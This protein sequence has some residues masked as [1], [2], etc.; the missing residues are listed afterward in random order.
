M[1]GDKDEYVLELQKALKDMGFFN[2]KPTGYFGTETQNAVIAFQKSRQMS[3]DGKAGE[4]TRKLLLG[5]DYKPLP[6][7]RVASESKTDSAKD[8][9]DVWRVGDRG[10]EVAKFQKRLKEL[11]YYTYSKI[12]QY[13]GPITE[14]AVKLFQKNNGLTQDGILGPKTLAKLNSKNAKKYTAAKSTTKASNTST[15]KVDKMISIAKKYIGKPYVLGGN[16]PSKF[17]C[18]GFT[19]FVMNQMGVNIPRTANS[20]SQQSSWLKVSKSQLKAGDL[21]F[22]DTR[23]GNPTIGH[24]GIYLGGGKFIHAEP[25]D[26]VNIDSMSSGYYSNNFK[27]GRRIYQ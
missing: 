14:K 26:G 10:P 12:T 11:N 3:M 20:Q 23:N 19:K 2:G 9:P 21:V 15:S 6:S 22:F 1:L 13:Y 7:D 27:W 16:G 5:N 4:V 24:V 8:D 25:G 17:D 18:S